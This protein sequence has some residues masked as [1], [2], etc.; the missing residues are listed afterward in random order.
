MSCNM[1]ID[2]IH[3]L[4]RSCI[5]ASTV[6]STH[7]GQTD[8]SFF[9]RL[10]LRPRQG[11]R[12]WLTQSDEVQI[13]FRC[14]KMSPNWVLLP[15]RHPAL[16]PFPWWKAM[17]PVVRF[18]TRWK[19]NI[20]SISRRYHNHFSS[21]Y[22]YDDVWCIILNRIKQCKTQ[23]RAPII[24]FNSWIRM[25]PYKNARCAFLPPCFLEWNQLIK[26]YPERVWG[27]KGEHRNISRKLACQLKNLLVDY[28]SKLPVWFATVA[29]S[30]FGEVF[31]QI[32]HGGMS[33][34]TANDR[35]G[36]TASVHCLF[37]L[38]WL[39]VIFAMQ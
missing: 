29:A 13:Q 37:T 28:I 8:E 32:F 26:I 1:Y 4:I 5:V 38:S 35:E 31:G 18:W 2:D 12:D 39:A 16:L 34:W 21:L 19:G 7:W 33:S 14:S 24:D 20:L 9:I 25:I 23:K 3:H 11:A 36:W 6:L 17:K 30:G 10:I 27:R 15:L 22:M